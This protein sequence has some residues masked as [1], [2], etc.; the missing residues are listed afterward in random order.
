[1]RVFS[2]TRLFATPWTVALQG[3]LSTEFSRQEY[4]SGLPFPTLGAL[5][6]PEIELAN[7][8]LLH[9]QVASLPL[10]HLE[11]SAKLSLKCGTNYEPWNTC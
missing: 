11:K 3:L 2:S 8:S 1:M 4:W 9:W 10:H 5:S 7:S 6:D